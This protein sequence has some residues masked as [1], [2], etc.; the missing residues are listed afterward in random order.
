[1]GKCRILDPHCICEV[2]TV[3]QLGVLGIET[4]AVAEYT[5]VAYLGGEFVGYV[6]TFLFNYLELIDA[7]EV[8]FTVFL[9]VNYH[10]ETE[11]T[12][13]AVGV[14]YYFYV[15]R[16]AGNGAVELAAVAYF[17]N[18]DAVPCSC[19]MLFPVYDRL[20]KGAV[21]GLEAF[22]AFSL[23]VVEAADVVFDHALHCEVGRDVAD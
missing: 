23:F 10:F 5:G 21:V 16:L 13:D 8:F 1:M 2:L 7:A 11:V 4:E 15:E 6:V 17:E 12:A 18:L 3:R 9:A 22:A 20:G 14:Y 19:H